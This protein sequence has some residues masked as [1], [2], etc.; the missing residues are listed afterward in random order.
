MIPS[1][2]NRQILALCITST[3]TFTSLLQMRG[4]S[5]PAFQTFINYVLLNIIFTPYTIYRY[6]I[7]G[8]LRLV[9]KD[10]WRCEVPFPSFI[11]ISLAS[12][13]FN[14]RN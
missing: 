13:R 7:K 12:G 5:I 1:H 9:L 3:N 14:S 11:D 10:G 6:G 2:V 4:T 8:W